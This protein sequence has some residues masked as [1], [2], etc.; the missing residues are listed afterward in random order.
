MLTGKNYS[1]VLT[2]PTVSQMLS[3][4][5]ISV[6]VSDTATVATVVSD[7]LDDVLS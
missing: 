3:E 5:V 6:T 7:S 2:V 4:V 1:I